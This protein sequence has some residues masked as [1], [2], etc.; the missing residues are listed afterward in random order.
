MSSV[1]SA[2][3]NSLRVAAD[4][5]QHDLTP[6]D[7]HTDEGLL[8]RH[9]DGD[10]AALPSLIRRY[11]DELLHFLTRFL[12]SRATA[13]DVFQET[14]LQIHQSAGTFDMSRRFKPWLF[15]IAANKARD[16]HRKHARRRTV[17]LSAS[18]A[19]N[20]EGQSFVD[21]MDADLPSPDRPVLDAERSQ[22]VKVVIDEM[23]VHLR[24]ILLLSY[25]QQLSYNQIADALEIPLGTVKSRL[26]TA[27]AA[28]GRGW[29]RAEAQAP[30]LK[31]PQGDEWTN[32]RMND[33]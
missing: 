10:Q 1:R 3:R 6:L 2:K 19:G 14:F 20:G 8:A 16:K 9:I 7:E 29:T 31:D 33:A 13:E 23:P 27:V 4:D 28:F 18:V 15:T 26:H 12:G 24:E 25:F 17:S 30:N 21:L 22:R 11:G 5:H 32:G